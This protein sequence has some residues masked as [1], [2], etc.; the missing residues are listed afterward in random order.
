MLRKVFDNL[1]EDDRERLMLAFEEEEEC[2]IVI[3]DKFIGVNVRSGV[4]IEITEGDFSY[5]ELRGT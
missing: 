2:V 4:K 1:N 3:D 5:G